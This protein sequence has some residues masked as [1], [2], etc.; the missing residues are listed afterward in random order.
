VSVGGVPR[1]VFNVGTKVYVLNDTYISVIDSTTNNVLTT[2]TPPSLS[3]SVLFD[4]VYVPSDQSLW[5]TQYDYQVTATGGRVFRIDT[6]SNSITHTFSNPGT[7]NNPDAA[8]ALLSPSAIAASSTKVYVAL[9][10]AAALGQG[11]KIA[12]FDIAN[13]ARL[14]N[15][16]Y[17]VSTSVSDSPWSM[18]VVGNTLYIFQGNQPFV[19]LWN[20]SQATQTT[21][22]TSLGTG[23]GAGFSKIDPTGSKIFF[24]SQSSIRYLDL[25]TNATYPVATGLTQAQG[26]T[27]DTSGDVIFVAAM[28][29]LLALSNSGTFQTLGMVPLDAQ[30]YLRG[31]DLVNNGNGLAISQ[32]GTSNNVRM[33][34]F[35]ELTTSNANLT[36]GANGS[37]SAPGSTG[38]WTAPTYTSTSLPAGLSLNPSTGVISGTPTTAQ[39]ST[40]VTITATTAVFTR[41]S[42][43]AITI[44]AASATPPQAQS[45]SPST[46]VPA[47]APV[48]SL[49]Q[50]GINL[51]PE[52]PLALLFLVLG[53]A[54]LLA[55]RKDVK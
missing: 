15:L 17:S 7:N 1:G 24:G 8:G 43:F 50:T 22:S 37:T 10:S 55:A 12:V 2:I 11:D 34:P 48:S 27:F 49:A 36:V 16:A 32:R 18:N 6:A 44:T 9:N 40:N 20:I 38:F 35:P 33:I 39:P 29:N 30:S 52:L 28:P 41:S 19:I 21:I 14:A 45:P 25:T 31:I 51:Y 47:S 46:S 26:L 4:A 5:V 53:V 42:T 54:C 13:P 3:N 23:A